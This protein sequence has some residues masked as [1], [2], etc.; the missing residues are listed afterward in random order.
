M[1]FHKLTHSDAGEDV[2][3][4]S[5]EDWNEWVSAT[6]LRGY[7]LKNTLGDWLDLYG[8][9]HG[10]VRDDA[11]EGYDE[12]LDFFRFV[13]R[14][15]VAFEEAVAAFLKA[16]TDLVR[17]SESGLDSQDLSKAKETF[18][19]LQDG[20]AVVHQGI[21]WNPEDRTY[22]APD[23]LIRSDVF[24][25]LFPEHLDPGEAERPAP[26]L[27]RPWHYLVVDAK[28]TKL[29]LGK[30][31]KSV[32]ARGTSTLA[33]KG[34]LFVYNAAL[35]RLQG[36]TPPNAFLLGRGLRAQIH[37]QE[38]EV[39]VPERHRSG[40]ARS[41]IHGRRSPREDHR[42]CRM[43]P[44]ASSGGTGLESATRAVGSGA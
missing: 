41:G 40:A 43:D 9:A 18:S 33:Y 25:R 6:K 13:V 29:H 10:F 14:Q 19:A 2:A 17:I 27:D 23:F 38:A 36:Y 37:P 24:E 21:L 12:R 1:K 35:G 5:P 39:R 34:Q 15:G 20:R 3:P 28:F 42:G 11:R 44:Q 22:G 7:L 26:E 31:R 32:L 4:R 8:E 16:R 30:R